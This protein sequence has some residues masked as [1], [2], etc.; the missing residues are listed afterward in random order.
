ME[1]TKVVE[2]LRDFNRWRDPDG[3]EFHLHAKRQNA[4]H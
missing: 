3:C 4:S 2:L 1:L